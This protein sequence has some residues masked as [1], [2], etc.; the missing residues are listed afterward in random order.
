M[1]PDQFI[2]KWKDATLKERS[3][4]QEHFLDLCRLLDEP[5]PAEADPTGS[6]YCFERGAAKAGG[7]DGWRCACLSQMTA[8]LLCVYHMMWCKLPSPTT[9]RYYL[10]APKIAIPEIVILE[11]GA[12]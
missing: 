1:T 12:L 11:A 5:T 4:S 3:A 9:Y 8:F 6:W 7:G 10:W 2:T